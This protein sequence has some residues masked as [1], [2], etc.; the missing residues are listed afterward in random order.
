MVY[1][2]VNN[3]HR[4][5]QY[6]ATGEHLTEWTI[7]ASAPGIAAGPSSEVYVTINN[8]HRVVQYSATGQYLTEWNV[9]AGTPGAIAVAPGNLT[10]NYNNTVS[11]GEV[12]ITTSQNW[13]PTDITPPEVISITRNEPTPTSKRFVSIL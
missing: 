12:Y 6:S 3:S 7:E 4:V 13:A 9:E 1:V 2:I 8:S 10:D 11:G 5:V